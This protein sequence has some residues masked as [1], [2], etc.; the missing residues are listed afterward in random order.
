M[1]FNITPPP[2]E[3][4]RKDEVLAKAYKNLIYFGRAFLPNDFLKKSES[5][6]F[7]YEMGQKMIDT[8]PELGYVILYQEVMVNL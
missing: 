6:P 1:S 7:H 5:A 4:D 2:S 3:M 8:K